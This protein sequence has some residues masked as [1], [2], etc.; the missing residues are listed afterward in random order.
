MLKAFQ[1]KISQN[2]A[3]TGM[4]SYIIAKNNHINRAIQDKSGS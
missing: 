1:P 4:R 3:L 2:M